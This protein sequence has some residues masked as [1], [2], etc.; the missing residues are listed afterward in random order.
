MLKKE[1]KMLFRKSK[2][3][4]SSSMKSLSRSNCV[5]GDLMWKGPYSKPVTT[6]LL[7]SFDYD[8]CVITFNLSFK[9]DFRLLPTAFLRA[10]KWRTKL[11]M[12][13]ASGDHGRENMWL[14]SDSWLSLVPGLASSSPSCRHRLTLF[15]RMQYGPKKIYQHLIGR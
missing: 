14:C 4:E 6:S 11:S 1:A 5:F 12:P 13:L 8:H 15:A 7:S 3:K 9:S 2:V 10:P